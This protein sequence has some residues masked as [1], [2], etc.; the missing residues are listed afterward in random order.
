MI[1]SRYIPREPDDWERYHGLTT[2]AIDELADRLADGRDGHT[3]ADT[4]PTGPINAHVWLDTSSDGT[5]TESYSYASKTGTYTATTSD[6]VLL[7][8]GTWTLTIP[9]PVG[10]GGKVYRVKNTGTGAITV[11]PAA[12]TIDGQASDVISPG[13]ARMYFSDNVAWRVL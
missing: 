2:S 10:V 4:A 7:C 5:V 9:T 3:V 12:S 1:E 8:S 13:G 6:T 11:T